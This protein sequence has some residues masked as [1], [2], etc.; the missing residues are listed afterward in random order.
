MY[1]IL[2]VAL[3]LMSWAIPLILIVKNKNNK[4]I[5]KYQ[6]MSMAFCATAFTQLTPL[7]DKY[8]IDV[9]MQGHDHTYSRTFQLE[10][11]GKDHTSY[12]TYGY[13]GSIDLCF[14]YFINNYN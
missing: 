9:V 10:G 1:N 7:M 8:K 2:S 11:D 6:I 14:Y 12:S 13:N 3:V 5:G 4:S